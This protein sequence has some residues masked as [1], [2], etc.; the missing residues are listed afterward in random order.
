MLR[1]FNIGSPDQKEEL[2]DIRLNSQY[3]FHKH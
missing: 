3:L 2:L 1:G